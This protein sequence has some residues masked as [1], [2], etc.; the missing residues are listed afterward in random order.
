M[1]YFSNY[2]Q[3]RGVQECQ[4]FY[5]KKNQTN[6]KIEQYIFQVNESLR[7]A[8][9]IRLKKVEMVIAASCGIPSRREQGSLGSILEINRL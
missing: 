6:N 7:A 9:K 1:V 5:G 2:L 3:S 4:Q 8:N